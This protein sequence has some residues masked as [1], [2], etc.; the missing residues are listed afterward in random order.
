MHWNLRVKLYVTKIQQSYFSILYNTVYLKFSDIAEPQ[1]TDGSLEWLSWGEL[2]NRSMIT[3]Y[4][5]PSP[6]DVIQVFYR[7]NLNFTVYSITDNLSKALQAEAISAVES[8]KTAKLPLETLERCDLK[9]TVIC[10]VQRMNM[11]SYIKTITMI[12]RLII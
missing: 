12:L 6:N 3:N 10:F 7:I 1:K 11:V 5:L 4:R 2:G 9:K 8:Q